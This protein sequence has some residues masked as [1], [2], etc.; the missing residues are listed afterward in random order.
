MSATSDVTAS[1]RP[2]HGRSARR[3]RS[4]APRASRCRSPPASLL[5]RRARHRARGRAR[6]AGQP[7]RTGRPGRASWS[8]ERRSRSRQPTP[9]RSCRRPIR[10]VLPALAGAFG[11]LFLN[12]HVGGAIAALVLMFVSYAAVVALAG[13]LSAR[14]VVIAIVAVHAVV[15]LGPPLAST[16]IFSYQAY[17]R[18]GATVWDQ[19]LHARP[20][21]DQ[22][23]RRVPLH[24]SQM[25]DHHPERLR[26]GVHG[27]HLP[28]G[29]AHDRDERV[30]LQ[31]DRGAR[32]PRAGGG[33]VALRP[34]ARQRPR[35][36]GGA[37]G[38]QP[39]AGDLRSGRRPQ[40][41][42][43]AAGDGRAASTPSSPRGSGWAAA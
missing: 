3:R 19:P 20:L 28:A 41:P 12:L 39:A 34:A 43:H 10:P 32:E 5:P 7:A 16:D 24:R 22:P 4:R 11:S 2:R 31:V 33:G 27:L 13:Q 26:P 23:G 25:V 18:M 8:A 37:G 14:V 42:A 38:P 1:S 30:R 40:R 21:R 17:A 6:A 35:Q 29:P 9:S 36:G 15:L